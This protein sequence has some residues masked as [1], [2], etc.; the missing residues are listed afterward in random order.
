MGRRRQ[1]RSRPSFENGVS[2]RELVRGRLVQPGK[3]RETEERL[4]FQMVVSFFSL[5]KTENV[6]RQR[7]APSVPVFIIHYA[8]LIVVNILSFFSYRA[9]MFLR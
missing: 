7:I 9:R 6:G 3:P 5:E 8:G 4:R 1:Q 2:S